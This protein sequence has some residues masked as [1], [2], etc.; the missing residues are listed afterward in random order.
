ML[1]LCHEQF[2]VPARFIEEAHV[3]WLDR[4]AFSRL[5]LD[6]GVPLAHWEAKMGDWAFI[7][8]LAQHTLSLLMS[9][10]QRGIRVNFT[11]EFCSLQGSQDWRVLGMSS[12]EHWFFRTIRTLHVTVSAASDTL[13]W[14]FNTRSFE[15]MGSLGVSGL[16]NLL[17][18]VFGWVCDRLVP[19]IVPGF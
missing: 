17:E 6:K 18:L 19:L 12:L 1:N 4:F 9:L 11:W 2:S 13:I 7:C 15:N 10:I 5:L 14:V 16:L 8:R 3:S